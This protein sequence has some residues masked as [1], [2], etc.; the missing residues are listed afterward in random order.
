MI[1]WFFCWEKVERSGELSCSFVS[2][3][4]NLKRENRTFFENM[5][6]SV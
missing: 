2:L 4:D 5:E 6:L 3:L 1:T